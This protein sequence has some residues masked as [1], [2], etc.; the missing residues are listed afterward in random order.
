MA[1]KVDIKQEKQ[2]IRSIFGEKVNDENCAEAVDYYY[3]L[4]EEDVMTENLV[5]GAWLRC[6]KATGFI[7]EIEGVSFQTNI[8]GRTQLKV[9]R[10]NMVGERAKATIVDRKEGI[11]IFLFGNCTCELNPKEKYMLMTNKEARHKGTCKYLMSLANYWDMLPRSDSEYFVTENFQ[12]LNMQSALFCLRGAWIYPV[13]SGQ[14]VTMYEDLFGE[15]YVDELLFAYK[16]NFKLEQIVVFKE[17]REYFEKFPEMKQGNVIFA[18]EGLGDGGGGVNAYHP[19]GQF[20]ALFIICKEGQLEYAIDGST[21][22]DQRNNAV[23]KDGVYNAVY[24][25]HQG[26]YSALQLRVLENK[27][28]DNI[29]AQRYDG[30][31]TNSDSANGI[32]LHMAKELNDRSRWS[33]GCLTVDFEQYYEFGVKAGFIER[34][35]DE[36]DYTRYDVMKQVKTDGELVGKLWGNIVVNRK[37]MDESERNKYFENYENY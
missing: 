14:E 15:L 21:L 1:E 24:W 11:N 34:C 6:E 18:F 10:K 12:E 25:N 23:I 22:P 17:I 4:I 7:V 35:D 9:S 36:Q 33:L 13:T 26:D 8:G 28:N 20:K 16:N 5:D 2:I 37:Y 30:R 29:P 3:E 27:N 31:I 19:E 32:N